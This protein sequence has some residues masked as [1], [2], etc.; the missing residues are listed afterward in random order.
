VRLVAVR[1]DD[2][3]EDVNAI[4]EVV[5]DCYARGEIEIRVYSIVIGMN[6]ASG[7]YMCVDRR[8]KEGKDAHKVQ[9]R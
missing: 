7:V 6:L 1:D 5:G 3:R 8:R 4:G 9:L 2:V